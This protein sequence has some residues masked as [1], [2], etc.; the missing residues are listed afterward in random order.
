VKE[1]AG[2][3]AAL[4]PDASAALRVIEYFDRLVR[5]GGSATRTADDPATVELL[6]DATAPEQLRLQ[7]ARRIGLRDGDLARAV[8]L[9]DGGARVEPATGDGHRTWKATQ[10]AGI[11]PA[12]PVRDLP[13]SWSAARTALRFAAD[14]TEHDPGPRMVEADRLGGLAL[15][16]ETVRPGTE[17]I[18]DVRALDD[19]ASAG[20][21]VLAT[22]HAVAESQ[23]LR[24]A[25]SALRLHH[26]TLQDRITHAEHVLGWTVR[27]PHGRLR[28]QLAL[29][30]RQ[31]HH[32]VSSPSSVS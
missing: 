22:L 5:G 19:A 24:S 12:V 4:D 17:P 16:A 20:P 27:D 11:G 9:G 13:A 29:V 30:L 18:P 10:R 21:W 23:S 2:R 6:V 31:L 26:S 14:G 7:A 1:L 28:L 25:A 32:H 15:L 3:L 8:A